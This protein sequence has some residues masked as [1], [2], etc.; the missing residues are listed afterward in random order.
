[1]D[2]QGLSSTEAAA[3]RQ[4]FGPNQLP[5]P[6]PP[7]WWQQLLQQFRNPLIFILSIAALL[8]AVLGYWV[9]SAIIVV[10]I[11]VNTL[12]GF[13]Q[14]NRAEHAIAALQAFMVEQS[15]VLRDGHWQK[16]PSTQLVP[17]DWVRIENGE[18]IPADLELLEAH[19]LQVDE[20][21]LTGESLPV[22][23]GI[24]ADGKASRLHAGTLVTRGSGIGKVR[25]IG[26]ATAM[27]RIQQLMDQTETRQSPLLLR[28]T[29]LS[30]LLSAAV[31][32]LAAIAAAVAWS[33]GDHL[34]FA[35]LAAISLA[36]AI[37][38]EGLPAVI[39]ITL[40]L[41]VQRMARQ[42]AIIR[43]LPAVETLGAVTVI[44]TDKTGTLTENRMAVQE[45]RLAED[46]PEGRRRALEVMLLCNDAEILADGRGSGDPLEQALI[47]HVRKRE[48]G[49][50]QTAK[51]FPRLD[52]RPFDHERPYMATLHADRIA[53]KGAPEYVLQHC[54]DR[55]S[56]EFALWEE[57]ISEMANLGLRTIALAEAGPADWPTLDAGI[58][59]WLGVAA[60]L[61]PPRPAVP[62][63]IAACRT[64]GIRVIMVTGDHPRT[65]ATIARQ[66]GLI[67][68]NAIQVV[69]HAQ[70]LSASPAERLHFAQEVNVF[71]RVQ[72]ADKL[73]LVQAL[74]SSGEVVAMTGDGV[75]DAPALRRAQIGVAMGLSGSAV[76][77][78]AAAMIL[79]DDD[80]SHIASAVAEGR[81]VYHNI[82]QTVLFMLPTS[83]AQGL[84]IFI[85]VIGGIPLPI[86]PLQILWV[87]TATAVTL[88]LVFAFMGAKQT[89]MQQPPRPL[90]EPLITKLLWLRIGIM[91]TM[92]VATVFVAFTQD[93]AASGTQHA[94][95]LAVNI[96]M[97]MEGGVLLAMYGRWRRDRG[98][99]IL[100]G[101]LG[102]MILLQVLF[103][104]WPLLQT[105]FHST[106]MSMKDLGT[107]FLTTLLAWVVTRLS[108]LIRKH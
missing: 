40:A 66:V 37:I 21:L 29:H 101:S 20:S 38:P 10:V 9:D 54:L 83:F 69:D 24:S 86:T 42:G 13:L 15:L 43:Q 16:L 81:H 49:L 74:Q 79:A 64:A 71:A 84:I 94:H 8:S 65:A 76:A 22:E 57:I 2:K 70:W 102:S 97:A 30:R 59:R 23:K 108:M 104:Q 39:S 53:I 47:R 93:N 80:F 100:L 103:S 50:L 33:R 61:D 92:L 36:V 78:E 96:L 25:T 75:N 28:I 4:Q 105:I 35:I 12:L 107:I 31:L 1:M 52:T 46:T 56:Q 91:T 73:E 48:A 89:Y 27:G 6:T 87:N 11:L 14:E 67:A 45:V 41:G 72:P 77:R 5:A 82:Q 60:L 55:Q 7:R 18:R 99:W 44:C 85:A 88:A 34:E 58:W 95:T 26:M 98:D 62:A 68:E 32:L 51:Q 106:A 90:K 63:A 17:G 19:H 3:L